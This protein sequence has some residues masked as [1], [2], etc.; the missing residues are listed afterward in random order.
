MPSS[1]EYVAFVLEECDGLNSRVMMGEYVLYYGGKV[2]GAEC[3][4]AFPGNPTA[5]TCSF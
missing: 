4:F 1:K 3:A 2:V 5:R